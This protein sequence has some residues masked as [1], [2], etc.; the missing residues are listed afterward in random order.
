MS[1]Q[2]R[3]W[4]AAITLMLLVTAACGA[5]FA[6]DASSDELVLRDDDGH[7]NG[8]DWQ[9]LQTLLA[10]GLVVGLIFLARYLLH[11]FS[12]LRRPS[13]TCGAMAVIARAN[14]TP[15]HQM[16]LVRMGRRLLLLGCGSEGVAALTE[17]TDSQEIEE[18]LRAVDS[19]KADSFKKLFK[20]K[21]TGD[22]PAQSGGAVR[23]VAEKMRS[24]LGSE[25]SQEAS[26]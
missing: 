16:V 1:P 11:K 10:L 6:Q 20:R 4:I 8:G 22:G 19:A 18:L 5:L 15:K 12:R 9:W 21:L 14:L 25:D 23:E 2:R 13:G 24:R 3:R 17:I 7:R 26:Q